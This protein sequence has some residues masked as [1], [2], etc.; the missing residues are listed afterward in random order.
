MRSKNSESKEFAQFT[1]SSRL[2][3]YFLRFKSSITEL[4]FA[5]IF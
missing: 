5:I 3:T 2:G 4:V 1:N